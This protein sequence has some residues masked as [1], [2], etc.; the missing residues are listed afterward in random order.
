[1]TKKVIAVDIRFAGIGY[2][3]FIHQTFL[4]I[5]KQYPQHSFIFIFDKPYD[6]SFIFSKNI[7]SVIV[8]K[9]GIP[10]LSQIA[11][12]NKVSSL[13]KKYKADVLI[14]AK[15]LLHTKVPQCLIFNKDLS[16][17]NLKKTKAIV[18]SSAFFKQNIIT[19]YKIDEEKI[20]V[21]YPGVN[22]NFQPIG[23]KEREKVK[24][25]YT[26]A[27]EYFL[28]K[29]ENG[30]ENNLYNLLKAFSIFKKR[31][32]SNIQLLISTETILQHKFLEQLNLYKFKDEVK[33]L[34]DIRKSELA[35]I[36]AGAY[37]IICSTSNN[38]FIPLLEAMKC[39]VPVIVPNAG[40]FPEICGD[41]AL[42]V[43]PNDHKDIAE[44]MMLI[45]KDEKIRSELI[46]K[47]KAQI[48]KFSWDI[49]AAKVWEII[50]KA[51]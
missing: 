23:F 8:K 49:A 48:K 33:V 35:K 31:Q 32:K 51:T 13:L 30:F 6:T 37:A 46:E 9:V 28:Y 1:M 47:G 17:K 36:T 42:Y 5:T 10:L 26:D 38:Y 16:E 3:N 24:E 41:G 45:F 21:I 40:A 34:V 4:R 25:E 22:E 11:A 27:K 15:C 14:T 39:S 12:D 2:Q 29:E 7:I 19:K 44:K 20:H 50:E 43:N 18:T